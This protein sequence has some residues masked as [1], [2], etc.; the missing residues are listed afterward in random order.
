MSTHSSSHAPYPV[1]TVQEIRL[2]H[3]QARLAAQRLR[4]EASSA[5][6]SALLAQARHPMASVQ[7]LS[8][9]LTGLLLPHSSSKVIE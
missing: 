2:L 9:R 5:F 1:Y 7:G 8:H 4:K 6:W 3:I